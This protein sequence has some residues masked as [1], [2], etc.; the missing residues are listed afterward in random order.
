V[1][2]VRL[3][4]V[5][6]FAGLALLVFKCIG[7]AT[8]GGYVLT[9]AGAA[10][11]QEAAPP[12][13]PSADP[14]M[15]L[16]SEPTLTDSSPTLTDQAPTL[17][18]PEAAKSEQT[19]A[20]DHTAAAADPAQAAATEPAP[21]APDLAV[22]CTPQ[23]ADGTSAPDAGPVV[24]VKGETLPT[25]CPLPT[26]AI[27][28]TLDGNGNPVPLTA[29]DGASLTEKQILERLSERR[30]QLDA[31]EAELAI[32]QSLV[33]AA[34]KR[35]EERAAALKEVETRITAL[36]DQKKVNEDSEFKGLVNLYESMKPKDASQIFNTLD[37][38]ILT[39][40]A[41]VMN[42]KKL[43]PIMAAMDPAVADTLTVNLAI[44][45]PDPA[46]DPAAMDLS[47]LPQIVGQ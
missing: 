35:L 7:L 38:T 14:T 40:L 13:D 4:P 33:D 3:L 42:P 23:P 5:F 20:A 6:V 1:K 39:K 32:R 46:A 8:N 2:P 29:A 24:E 47:A 31:F 16:P 34:E 44:N 30:T 18:A 36:V 21:T 19:V 11:A 17:A 28:T 26:D 10:V 22:G 12:A 43:A 9:G 25:D 37:M 27:A 41:R 15:T 45:E